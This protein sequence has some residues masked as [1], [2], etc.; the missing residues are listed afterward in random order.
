MEKG[1]LGCAIRKARIEHQLS[2]EELAELVDITPTHMKHIE[3][4]HRKP[5]LSVLFDLVS[6]LSISLDS[7]LIPEKSKENE[8]FQK[9]MLLLGKCNDKQLK[10]SI[11]LLEALLKNE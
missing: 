1:K 6:V 5:S 3:S 11:A 2:Q 8:L 10:I 7:L 9:A 4:E